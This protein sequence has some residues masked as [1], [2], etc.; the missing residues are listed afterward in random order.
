MDVKWQ[1]GEVSAQKR[2]VWLKLVVPVTNHACTSM[3]GVVRK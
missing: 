3:Q 1:T 2:L